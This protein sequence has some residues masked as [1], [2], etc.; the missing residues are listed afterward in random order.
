MRLKIILFLIL[1]SF[2][3]L[4]IFSQS[5]YDGPISVD[6]KLREVQGN[7]AATDESLLGVGFAPDELVV[8]IWAMDNLS[9]YPWTGGACLQDNNFTPTNTGTNSIDFNNIFASF[10][11]NSMTVPQYL[12]FRID[13]WEDDLPSDG[14]AGFCSN[15]SVC[16]WNGVECCGV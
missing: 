8:K 9:I 15:G 6:V 7:F 11:Y 14:L 4:L 16:D 2:N 13:T 10:I 3:S 5:F 12:D 1:F